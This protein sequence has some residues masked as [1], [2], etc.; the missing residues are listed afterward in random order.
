MNPVDAL[1]GPIEW[2]GSSVQNG[3]EVLR[4]GGLETEEESA[5]YEV[6]ASGGTSGCAATSPVTPTP[7]ARLCCWFPR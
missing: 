3:L 1:M 5:P 6:V 4:L 2:L 7:R